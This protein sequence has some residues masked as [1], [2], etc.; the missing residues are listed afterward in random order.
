METI[1]RESD[2]QSRRSAQRIVRQ[3]ETKRIVVAVTPK[4]GGRGQ[5]KATVYRH[6]LDY[7]SPINSDTTVALSGQQTAT[8]TS[9]F[10]DDKQRPAG[11]ESATPG[12]TKGDI[13]SLNSDTTV[14]PIVKSH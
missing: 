7:Q 9:P 1:A 8:P 5:D 14:T 11:H 13:Q 12:T 4:T 3:L 6:D 2:L 10:T